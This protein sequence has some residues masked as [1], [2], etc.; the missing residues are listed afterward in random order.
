[1]MN[2]NPFTLSFGQEPKMLIHNVNQFDEIK[3]SFSSPNPVSSTYLITGVRGSGKTVLL[4]CLAKYF[5]KQDDWIV[6]ELNPETDML[7]YLASSLYEQANLKIKFLKKEFSFSF[8]GISFSVSGNEP[9]SN[10]V[11]FLERLLG[12][13]AK[14]G[15]RIL[16]CVD[17]VSST[18]FMKV[19]ALQ[20]QIFIRKNFPLFLLMSGLFENVRNLQNEKSLT[21]LYR[22][23]QIYVSPLGLVNIAESFISTLGVNRDVA[24]SMAQLTKGYAFAYQALGYI[25]FESGKKEVDDAVLESFDR[26]LRDYVYEKIY[27]DL[28]TTEKKI[29]NA[30]ASSKTGG[31]A[32]IMQEL[33]IP[34]ESMS[35]YRD[36]LLKKGIIA[37]AGWGVIDFAL[38][39]FREYVLLMKEFY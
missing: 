21:F 26:Y 29:V 6:V 31:I 11:A 19:F 35:Q 3:N 22:A 18:P 33:N 13:L 7:E 34:R 27:Y 36:K 23:M 16:V 37:K 30:L 12:Y 38:P 25:M 39:R 4:S 15:K 2:I 17:D 32:E 10:V 20:F 5:E 8:H 28:P 14:K 9:V 24:I 1:M